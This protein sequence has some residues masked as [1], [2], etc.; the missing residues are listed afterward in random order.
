MCGSNKMKME[1]PGRIQSTNLKLNKLNEKSFGE[2]NFSYIFKHTKL[3]YIIHSKKYVKRF[4][5]SNWLRKEV[6]QK[7][8][9]NFKGILFWFRLATFQQT[10]KILVLE[11]RQKRW[12]NSLRWH[13]LESVISCRTLFLFAIIL[14]T[15]AI[16]INVGT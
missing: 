9:T 14:M 13:G 4:L 16:I 7:N 10:Q 3:T 11:T 2:E 12:K 8:M 5:A 1:T 6:I 15:S